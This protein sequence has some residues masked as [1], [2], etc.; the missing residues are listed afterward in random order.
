MARQRTWIFGWC[1]P[2]VVQVHDYANE[3]RITVHCVDAQAPD[4]RS[5]LSGRMGKRL[6][7]TAEQ[8][9]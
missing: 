5:S 4:T 8:S 6:A 7:A 3:G 9:R 1:E 2:S